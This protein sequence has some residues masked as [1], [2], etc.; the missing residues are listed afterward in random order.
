MAPWGVLAYLPPAG[1]ISLTVVS[2]R[3]RVDLPP[4]P[5]FGFFANIFLA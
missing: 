5:C 3:A 4:G 1:R 2:H